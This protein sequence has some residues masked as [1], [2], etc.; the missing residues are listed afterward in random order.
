MKRPVRIV[1]LL[2][3][4]LFSTG[5]VFYNTFYL[6]RKSFN[7]AEERRKSAGRENARRSGGSGYKRAAEK[8]EKVLEKWP[9]SKWY[10]DA[11][12]VNGVSHFY[13]KNY[14]RSE[15][16]LREL[17]VE[18][19]ESEF[20]REARLYL[21]QTRLQ[22][23]EEASAMIIFEELF[24]DS[25]NKDI[26]TEAAL[27][28][29][30]YYYENKNYDEAE[31]YFLSLID[32]LGDDE[33]RTISKMRIAEGYFDR[34][35]YK[36]AVENYLEILDYSISSSDRFLA[37]FRIG[38]CF[39]FLNDIEKGLEYFN[40]LADDELYFDSLSSVK[41]KI[42][43]GYEWDGDLVEAEQVYEEIA[44]E[45]ENKPAAAIANYNLGLIYQLDYEDYKK[46]KEFYDIVTLSGRRTD[47]Y[48]DALQ[49]SSNIGKLEEY[50]N[51][52]ELDTSATVEDIDREAETQY[53][54]AELYLEE[55]D[56]PDSALQ[57]FQYIFD[58]FPS[59]Y[60]APKALIASA[61]LKRDIQND[62]TTFKSML[63]RVLADYPKSDYIPEAIDL[64]GL[65]GTVADSG[66]ASKLYEKGEYYIFESLNLDSA[67]HYFGQIADSFPR[68]N[69]NNKA[70]FV[71]LWLTENYDS[72]GDSS[73][74][75]E[76]ASFADS[77]PDT[78]FGQEADRKL[79]IKPVQETY[80]DDDDDYDPDDSLYADTRITAPDGDSLEERYISP[81]E[82]AKIGPDGE[83]IFPVGHPPQRY[84]REFIYPTAAY[85][86]AFYGKLIFQVKIDP[87]GD[88][89]DA[90]LTLRS[91]SE[92]INEE[93]M[94]TILSAHF[95]TYWIPAELIDSYFW[96]EYTIK[97][98][99]A[100]R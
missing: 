98:P 28:L 58:E 2:L 18:F 91:P 24:L 66:Y 25:D 3:V 80:V 75:F 38:D 31:K 76:Y 49:R 69:L 53:L 78:K 6:A 45:Y 12:F 36:P 35:K 99:A 30:E 44:L 51:R 34:F 85:S 63:R 82:R 22:L 86:D 13:M 15:K 33:V 21:A 1:I 88:V 92:A 20:V 5:C 96:F 67:R 27:A 87:F 14:S 32:S 8:S 84:D 54:L 50:K 26:Q 56:K 4:V 11:L 40:I 71:L 72:P 61:I 60:L 62:T 89:A 39:Y 37:T 43:R 95:E 57:E 55:L 68:S 16:K 46:A 29:G 52:S 90:I 93:A 48:Q 77:F 47:V 70:R 64:L 23:N 81:E 94:E 73:L 59:A 42:A 19:P 10:D 65:S 79:I 17:I 9:N 74:Y 41:L 83:S 100:L 7:E 97:L